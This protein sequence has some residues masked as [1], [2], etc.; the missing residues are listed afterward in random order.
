M[1]EIDIDR[2]HTVLTR[3]FLVVCCGVLA[4]ACVKDPQKGEDTPDGGE[5]ASKYFSYATTRE[6]TVAIDYGFSDY[7]VLFEIYGGNPLAEVDGGLVKTSEEPLYRAATDKK[8]C[9]SGTVTLP[10][11]LTEVYL[12]S[13]YPG[14]VSPVKLTVGENGAI[15]YDQKQ[16]RSRAGNPLTRAL[17]TTPTGTAYPDRYKVLGNWSKNGRPDYLLDPADLTAQQY[18]DVKSMF[19][20][21][22]GQHIK[23][24]PQRELIADN[25]NIK[26][27]I[28]KATTIKLIFIKTTATMR[29]VF[30]Y[31]TYPTGQEPKSV[32]DIQPI[33]AFPFISTF[34]CNIDNADAVFTGDQVQLKY[35]NARTQRFE[36]EFPAGVSIGWFL[37]AYSFDPTTGT[38]LEDNTPVYYASRALN[39]NNMHR[40][41]ALGDQQSGRML[42]IGFEDSGITEAGEGNFCDAVFMLDYG[43]KDAATSEG[44][45]VMPEVPGVT[46]E[47]NYH[48]V[49]GT[50]AFED[51]WPSQG[52]YDMN[53][54]VVT[55]KSTVYKNVLS[56]RATKVV[57]RFTLAHVGGTLPCGF[58]YQFDKLDKAAIGSVEVI[59]DKTGATSSFMQ[60]QM[61]EP[62][63]SKP[64][65]ILYY[66]SRTNEGA[67]FTVTTQFAY[68]VVGDLV[69]PP[70]NPYIVISSDK[71]RGREL[72]LAK[73]VP[74]D[75]ADAAYFGQ[76]SD[77][78]DPAQKLYYV[79]K[80]NFPFA[81]NIPTDAFSYPDE[82]VRIDKAY[83]SFPGW[84][85]SNG[86][87]QRDWYKK[88]AKK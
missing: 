40:S 19:S 38:V 82:K 70:Y 86:V 77:I 35:W 39:P 80:D 41:I 72:H 13:D 57:D 68:P 66:N 17:I 25:V 5:S 24:F 62:N 71:G 60:G 55:Y 1:K 51:L 50:L 69:Q 21:W 36:D 2:I 54:V 32:S 47:D 59:S 4:T 28:T 26:L 76:S 30:G 43:D 14:T 75:L 31:Y 74:T 61:L 10:A 27:N 12:Y 87:L 52:D 9:F 53:D 81:I 42:A 18:Y 20:L 63:Q 16:V 84:V 88:P 78:S 48:V 22:G 79:S 37:D 7:Q 23:D 29:N 33:I 85:S 44:T 49:N 73:G 46:D 6:Y 8:G 34:N 45:G 64:N 3:L 15:A 67:T 11:D 65:V 83:P 56:N 58:G